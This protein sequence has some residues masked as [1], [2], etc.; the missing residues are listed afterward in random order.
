MSPDQEELISRNLV[1][2]LRANLKQGQEAD[3]AIHPELRRVL[4]FVDDEL[5]LT[6]GFDELL[7]GPGGSLN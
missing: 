6:C 3:V 2:F 1:E 7:A 4:I 5:V